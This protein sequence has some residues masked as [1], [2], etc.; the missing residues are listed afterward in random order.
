MERQIYIHLHYLPSFQAH[1][2]WGL[3]AERGWKFQGCLLFKY[4]IKIEKMLIP[5]HYYRTKKF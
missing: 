2:H 1:Y 3:T 5:H 4:Q